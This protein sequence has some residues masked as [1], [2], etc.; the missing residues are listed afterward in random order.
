MLENCKCAQVSI[1]IEILRRSHL[2]NLTVHV[3]YECVMK[4]QMSAKIAHIDH[5]ISAKFYCFVNPIFPSC[6][7]HTLQF[8]VRKS[9]NKL[10]FSWKTFWICLCACSKF[11]IPC[12]T[13]TESRLLP[14]T[15]IVQ[16]FLVERLEKSLFVLV[17]K[18]LS[19]ILMAN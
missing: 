13:C 17:T 16:Y 19:S 6:A 14:R 5:F 18:D 9:N 12:K 10:L 3:F 8:I 11:W 1:L 15:I 2:N 4:M 7:V